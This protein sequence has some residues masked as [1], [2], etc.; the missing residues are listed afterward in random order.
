VYPLK[1]EK[2]LLSR[3]GLVCPAR[4][5]D[6]PDRYEDPSGLW[7][8]QR[9]CAGARLRLVKLGDK[10]GL[11][12]SSYGKVNAGDLAIV[13]GRVFREGKHPLCDDRHCVQVT[14]GAIAGGV[15]LDGKITADC[16]LESYLAACLLGSFINSVPQE[17]ANVT[18]P[19]NGFWDRRMLKSSVK[20]W[21]KR[22]MRAFAFSLVDIDED[23][24][25]AYG[26]C[27]PPWN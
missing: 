20:A 15:C 10:W 12:V 6:V 1:I 3:E 17:Q 13:Y 25:V 19:E 16:P 18:P 24:E 21:P 9:L 14:R 27:Y 4:Y 22:H 2:M 11:S 7:P 23:E 8:G 26:W 5:V